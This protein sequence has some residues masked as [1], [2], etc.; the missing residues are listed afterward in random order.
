LIFSA[1]ISICGAA[2]KAF[3]PGNGFMTDFAANNN[4]APEDEA[5]A[6]DPAQVA[7]AALAAENAE[8]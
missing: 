1:E 3:H 7:A 4:R 5:T 6:A 2:T 8:L